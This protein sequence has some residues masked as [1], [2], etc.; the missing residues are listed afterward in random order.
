LFIRMTRGTRIPRG[1]LYDQKTARVS[2]C[3]SRALRM[4]CHHSRANAE[5]LAAFDES[6]RTSHAAT[7][8]WRD[9]DI[10]TFNESAV[11]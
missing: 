3:D 4:A 10:A 2:D 8:T 7:S 6:A 5:E 9:D 1:D 11:A